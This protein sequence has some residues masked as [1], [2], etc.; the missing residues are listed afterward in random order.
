MGKNS[1]I[2]YLVNNTN[3]NQNQVLLDDIFENTDED[4]N[5]EVNYYLNN[6]EFKVHERVL[7]KVFDF[8]KRFTV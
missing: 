6:L 4:E 8:A 1:T 5:E 7:E 3:Q 2:F